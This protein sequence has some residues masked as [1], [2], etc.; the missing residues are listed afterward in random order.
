MNPTSF[1]KR[2]PFALFLS[3]LAMG[4]STLQIQAQTPADAVMMKNGEFCGGLF[5]RY[6]N[7]SKYW[8]ADSL[9]ENGN[10][11]TL[12]IHQA[13]AGFVLGITK[14]VNVYAS[15]PYVVTNPTAGQVRGDRGVQDAGLYAK[16][17]AIDWKSDAGQFLLLASAG[18]GIPSSNYIPEH[19]Y[20]IGMGCVYGVGRVIAAYEA[21]MGLYGRA[22][23]AFHLR[24]NS[25]IVRESYF[26]NQPYQSNIVDVPHALDVNAAVGYAT[27]GNQ[28]R[29]EAET[30]VFRTLG[31][32][33][34]RYWDAMFPSN[35]RDWLA[36]GGNVQYIPE[37][38]KGFGF[39]ATASSVLTG[40][41]TPKVL[42]VGGGVTY[43]FKIWDKQSEASM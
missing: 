14:Y 5:Y 1:V 20:A 35:D 21:E 36:L 11:G 12:N 18:A 15:L 3:V 42:T 8:Q 33:D 38:G 29:I 22:S 23:G 26:T 2:V 34:I 30:T 32:N 41:N 13:S 19:N 43:F 7:W 6:G 4:M 28:I 37:W 25:E 17:K 39:H 27:E 10:I 40:R 24:G 9:I 31:G 16:V